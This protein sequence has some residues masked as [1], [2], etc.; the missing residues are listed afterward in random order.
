MFFILP[1]LGISL[2]FLALSLGGVIDENAD[3][4]FSRNIKR[5]MFVFIF[6]SIFLIFLGAIS[7][8]VWG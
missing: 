1:L 7:I 8:I 5:V 6:I 3:A 4:D 2:F